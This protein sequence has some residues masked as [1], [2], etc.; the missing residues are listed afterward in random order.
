MALTTGYGISYNG[1]MHITGALT[2]EQQLDVVSRAWGMQDGGGYVFFPTIDGR[3]KTKQ[4]RIKGFN[5]GPAFLWPDHRDLILEHIRDHVN[6]DQYWCPSMFETNMRKSEYAMDEHALWADLDEVNPDDI[7]EEFRPTVAWQTSEEHYQA[8][9]LTRRPVLG[10]S[11]MG[12]ENQKLTYYLGADSNGWDTTQ[13]LRLPGSK[14][15]KY[16]RL[17]NNKPF[18]G[19]L[20]WNNGRRFSRSNFEDLPEVKSRSAEIRD[21]LDSDLAAVDPHEVMARVKLKL[22]KRV[23]EFLQAREAPNKGARSEVLWEIERELADAG[24]SLAEIVTLVQRSVWNKYAGRSDERL[25]LVTEATRALESAEEVDVDFSDKPTSTPRIAAVLANIK[26]PQWLVKDIWTRG[27]CGFIAGQPKSW[28]SWIALDMALSI[29]TGNDFLGAFSIPKPGPV[30]YIQEEDPAPR[31]KDRFDKMW[32]AKADWNVGIDDDGEPVIIPAYDLP[33][34][35]DIGIH[36]K[37]G[38]LL[39]DEVWQEWLRDTIAEGLDSNPYQAVILDPLM[40]MLGEVEDNKAQTMMTKVFR[41]LKTLAQEFDIAVMVVHH[42]RK[43]SKETGTV[44]GGQL[45][46]GSVANHAWTEDSLYISRS[47][48]DLHVEVES[49]TAPGGSFKISGIRNRSW[50]PTPFDLN[51]SE[52]EDDKPQQQAVRQAPKTQT[53]IPAIVK[54][55]NELGPSTTSQVAQAKGITPQAAWKQLKRATE[56]GLILN[57]S[58]GQWHPKSN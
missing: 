5:E 49:K 44:R 41:P 40:Y 7:D 38:I 53:K 27:S 28:K 30:L 35:P 16:D 19:R 25:R 2:P 31:L 17:K 45:M 46:L 13:L 52:D 21:I 9:W 8:L 18:Q 54:V 1:S 23:R 42:M 47:F 43:A 55:L 15:H 50:T 6:D 58:P 32:S 29:A 24:C 11:W 51:L 3:A 22:S 14:N 56:N 57:P 20:L 4:Q 26:P 37:S 12:G 34:D 39:S 33:R 48:N 36:L 10:V